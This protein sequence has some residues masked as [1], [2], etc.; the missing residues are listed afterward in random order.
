MP[1]VLDNVAAAGIKCY[2][3]LEKKKHCIRECPR[4]SSK[5]MVN[6]VD[7]SKLSKVYVLLYQYIVFKNITNGDSVFVVNCLCFDRWIV[8]F[9]L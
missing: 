9:P 6:T 2:T 3:C 5:C 4:A 7:V 8:T 1:F